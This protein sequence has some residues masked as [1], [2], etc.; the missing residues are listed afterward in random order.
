VTRAY[1][2]FRTSEIGIQSSGSQRDQ[3]RGIALSLH[4]LAGRLVPLGQGKVELSRSTRNGLAPYGKLATSL[5][6]ASLFDAV[7]VA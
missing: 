3:G 6:C 7:R 2:S 4:V 5:G 1:S